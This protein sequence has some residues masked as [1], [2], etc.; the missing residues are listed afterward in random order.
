MRFGFRVTSSATQFLQ[1]LA[2]ASDISRPGPMQDGYIAA[3]DVLWGFE[4]SRFSSAGDGTWKPLAE[5]TISKRKSKGESEPLP[6][7]HERGDLENSL[8]RGGV[9]HVLDV[10]ASA[11]IE[12]TQDPKARFHQDGGVN[13][14]ARTIVVEPDAQTLA[15][16]KAKVVE[17]MQAAVVQAASS[18]GGTAPGAGA[19]SA[20][21]IYPAAA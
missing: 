13:L 15:D 4:R 10:T 14:P 18:G 16:M 5:S 1:R 11:I 19:Q 7:L 17:G 20:A 3:S 2:E 8:H 21:Q 9:N 6:I 12:G